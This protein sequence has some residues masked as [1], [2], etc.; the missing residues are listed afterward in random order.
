MI[1]TNSTTL[2]NELG[3]WVISEMR[4]DSFVMGP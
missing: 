2:G 3:K 1:K 4:E